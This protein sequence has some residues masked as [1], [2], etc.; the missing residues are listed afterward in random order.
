MTIGFSFRAAASRTSV[1]RAALTCSAVCLAG[2]L[3]AAQSPAAALSGAATRAPAPAASPPSTL[4]QPGT[5][6][7]PRTGAPEVPEDISALSW[8]VADARTGDVLAAHNAHRRL[9]PASTLKTLFALTV[10]PALPG[11]TRHT[12]K[13]EELEGIGAGSS[14][15]GVAEG[16]TYKVADLWRGVFLNSGSDAVH[17]LAAM[18]GGWT[19]T[20]T[21]MQAKARS[22]GA[23]DTQVISPDGYDTPGQVSS[24]YDLAVFGRAGLRNPDFARYCSTPE[25]MFPG[26][27]GSTYGIQNTNRLLT[28][29]NGVEPYPGLIG[30]KNGYTTNA[31]NTLVAAARRGSRTLVVTV[32]N[33]QAGG[34]FT[35]YEEARSLL[36]WGFAADGRVDP[37]GTLLD[38]RS[39][40]A[41][42]PS[43]QA[44]RAT[45]AGPA[46]RPGPST[47]PGPGTRPATTA[48]PVA[49]A[50]PEDEG[51]GW[52]DAA[53]IAGA[54]VLGAAGVALALRLKPRRTPRG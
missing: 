25:A 3:A 2:V 22:L 18:N 1:T 34:G 40:P 42:G 5:Q 54:A 45:Q 44:G 14:M 19:N 52:S 23:R 8:V 28:G 35:V 50:S 24:A 26:E 46:G 33:P 53:E 9:P 43:A 7:R 47:R 51:L 12:V 37:V 32:M 15:V 10:I 36:D 13:E 4:Y 30:V 21:E 39:V 27:A 31:G 49:A 48:R 17:V 20:A 11:A 6:V 29:A 16:I 38:T 41:A